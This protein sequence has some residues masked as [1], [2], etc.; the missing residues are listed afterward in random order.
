MFCQFFL[1]RKTLAILRPQK[2]LEEKNVPRGV[3]IADILYIPLRKTF[4]DPEFDNFSDWIRKMARTRLEDWG[5]KSPS[6][7]YNINLKVAERI[8]ALA[9]EE[10]QKSFLEKYEVQVSSAIKKTIFEILDDFAISLSSNRVAFKEGKTTVDDEREIYQKLIDYD[11]SGE[12]YFTRSQCLTYILYL[13]F[14]IKRILLDNEIWD[15]KRSK[16]VGKR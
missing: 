3:W 1:W 7:R 4:P 16:N 6:E 13:E 10:R 12:E 2:P 14:K 8:D 11:L 15:Y 5:N 9:K